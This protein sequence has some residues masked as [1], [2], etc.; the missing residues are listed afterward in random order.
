MAEVEFNDG[1]SF[2]VRGGLEFND[3]LAFRIFRGGPIFPGFPKPITTDS[4]ALAGEVTTT[5]GAPVETATTVKT[6]GSTASA[7]TVETDSGPD[8]ESC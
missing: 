1:L 4:A 6:V 7:P 2:V 5:S 8:T 3:G